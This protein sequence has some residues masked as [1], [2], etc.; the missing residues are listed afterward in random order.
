MSQ[1]VAKVGTSVAVVPCPRCQQPLIDPQG[2]GWCK[3]CGYC[4]SLAESEKQTAGMQPKQEEA[5]PAPPQ[6]TVTATAAA[7][8]Q[9][10]LWIWISIIG[11]GAIAGGTYAASR[12]LHLTPLHQALLTT[13]QIGTGVVFMLIGQ[14]VAL[15]RIAPE[16]STITFWDAIIP[17]KLYGLVIKKLPSTQLTFYFAVW[18][19]TAIVSAAIFI[20]GLG[21]WLTYLPKGGQG[22]K[23]Q[24]VR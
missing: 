6:N 16:D 11:M 24:A 8:T 19:V 12:Y 13:I 20:G 17:F 10:P 14:F 9:M 4:R 21:H 23:T 3:I 22:Q 15:L 1:A 5:A 7:A 18:G 2:L